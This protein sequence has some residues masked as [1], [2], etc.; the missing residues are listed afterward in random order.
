MVLFYPKGFNFQN[1]RGTRICVQWHVYTTHLVTIEP[2][3]ILLKLGYLI[4]RPIRQIQLSTCGIEDFILRGKKVTKEELK[5]NF[6]KK[7]I[8]YDF[9]V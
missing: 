5:E 2:E 4:V 6:F 7:R 1:K 9:I 3:I 8:I